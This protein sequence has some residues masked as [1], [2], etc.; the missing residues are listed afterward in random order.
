[1]GNGE[2][3]L[4]L[5]EHSVLCGHTRL[6]LIRFFVA[7]EINA[8]GAMRHVHY[9]RSVCDGLSS[10]QISEIR[11]NAATQFPRKEVGEEVELCLS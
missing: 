11:R 10:H 1:M 2:A 5:L 7:L 3:A 6:A 8:D 4:R 9:C